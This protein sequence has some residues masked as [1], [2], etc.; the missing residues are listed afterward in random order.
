MNETSEMTLIGEYKKPCE[1]TTD[2]IYQL[3]YKRPGNVR[4]IIW[5]KTIPGFG[6]RIYPSGEKSYV[7]FY[8]FNGRKHLFTI[9]KW[10]FYKLDQ[11]RECAKIYLHNIEEGIDP[12]R[13]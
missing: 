12:L 13:K 8:Y 1:I 7:L 10:K 4:Q 6:V 3:V 5:D 9:G 2:M 11:A